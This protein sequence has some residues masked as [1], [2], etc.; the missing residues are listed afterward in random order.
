M[1]RMRR[2]IEI[3]KL[4]SIRIRRRGRGGMYHRPLNMFSLWIEHVAPL[5]LLSNINLLLL[6]PTSLFNVVLAAVF[7]A[8]T[9]DI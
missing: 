9:F 8:L 5:K 2:D 1:A 4:T 7:A 3:T 6:H